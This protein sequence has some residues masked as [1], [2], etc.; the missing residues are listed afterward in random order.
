M[1]KPQARESV[2]K[3]H[4]YVPGSSSI[5]GVD[6]VMKIASNENPLGASDVVYEALAKT[7][8]L[9]L[10]PD[11]SA[12]GVKD[13]VAKAY[14]LPVENLVCGAGSEQLISL[15]SQSFSGPGDEILFPEFGF[16]VYK[17][18]ALAVGAT[19]ISAKEQDCVVD[20][21][22]LLAAQSDKTKICYIANPGNPTGTMIPRTEL[23]R[24]RDGLRDDILLV[25]DAAYAEY[26]Y[27]ENYC[28]GSD[29]VADCIA[30]GADNVCVLH[31]FSKIYGLAAARL[32]WC[33][34]P[35]NVL[36]AINRVRGAFN[37]PT[38]SQV[39]GIAALTDKA[40]VGK[41]RSHN[42]KWVDQMTSDLEGLGLTVPT[43][44]GNFVLVKF[45]D[46]APQAAAADKF[47]QSR[48]VIIRPVAG[49]GLPEYLRITVGTDEE[50][51][52][53]LDGLKSF[54]DQ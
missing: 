50:C 54:F 44:H 12:S 16:L 7:R 29:L 19:P 33:Y 35:D 4:A 26:V 32:G 31:T 18:S 37:V 6:K 36:G 34:G 10:Y 39:A 53:C 11:P 20:V 21:D 42:K 41:S 25:I 14:G 52:A 22:T 9:H 5:E 24:L 13:A 15:I 28:D 43:S 40:H 48:G 49:Y 3:I 1:T 46:G 38:L 23:K 8:D 51:E 45:P 2:M 27:D 47:L 30:S 17:I